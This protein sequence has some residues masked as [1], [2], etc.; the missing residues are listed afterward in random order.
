M[1]TMTRIPKQGNGP[2]FAI[3]NSLNES[4]RHNEQEKLT[5]KRKCAV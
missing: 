3:R 1:H 2:I 5:N 4:H